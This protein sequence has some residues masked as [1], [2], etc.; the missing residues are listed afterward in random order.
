MFLPSHIQ[1]QTLQNALN[2]SPLEKDY[3]SFFSDIYKTAKQFLEQSVFKKIRGKL[4]ENQGKLNLR[5]KLDKANL[6]HYIAISELTYRQAL[7]DNFIPVSFGEVLTA[8]PPVSEQITCEQTSNVE[9]ENPKEP[10]S[11]TREQKDDP[12][13]R[14]NKM[15]SEYEAFIRFLLVGKIFPAPMETNGLESSPLLKVFDKARTLDEVHQAY[16]KLIKLWH[17]DLCSFNEKEAR[18][19][20]TWLKKAYNMLITNWQKFDPQNLSIPASRLEKLMNQELCWK[21]ETFWYA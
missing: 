21:A 13:E 19:R 12:K 4:E 9:P 14:Y 1:S 2:L 8:P 17:P 3:A 11:K 16:K 10:E 20:F 7:P 5:K 6:G 15:L 18:E